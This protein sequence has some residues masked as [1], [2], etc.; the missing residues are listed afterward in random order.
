[1]DLINYTKLFAKPIEKADKTTGKEVAKRI[2]TISIGFL[3]RKK[4]RD[5]KGRVRRMRVEWS[6]P[7]VEGVGG[8]NG[9]TAI[10]A[11]RKELDNDK[12]DRITMTPEKV[13]KITMLFKNKGK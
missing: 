5:K 4:I 7:I 1:M 11:F 9:L 6:L 8:L 2:G 10:K 3:T 13:R 12:A